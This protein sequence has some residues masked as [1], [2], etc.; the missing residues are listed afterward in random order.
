MKKIKE[1]AYYHFNGDDT[2]GYVSE[3]KMKRLIKG[4][5]WKRQDFVEKSKLLKLFKLLEGSLD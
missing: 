4:W 1:K 2:L 3:A 5:N